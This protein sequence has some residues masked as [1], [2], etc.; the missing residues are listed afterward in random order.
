MSTFKNT[1]EVTFE[2]AAVFAD[3]VAYLGLFGIEADLIDEPGE[4]LP[5]AA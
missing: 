1:T 3:P 5:L 4:Q 2:P